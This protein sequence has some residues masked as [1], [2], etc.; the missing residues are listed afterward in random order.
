ME[1]QSFFFDE[2]ETVSKEWWFQQMKQP[3]MPMR[4][5]GLG[6]GWL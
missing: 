5:N 2:D 1:G 6:Y 3:S 4:A